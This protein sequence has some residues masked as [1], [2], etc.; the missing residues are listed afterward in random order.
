MK[1]VETGSGVYI[2]HWFK[3]YWLAGNIMMP[4]KIYKDE[5]D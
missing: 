3:W 1:I 5:E 2:R 4:I